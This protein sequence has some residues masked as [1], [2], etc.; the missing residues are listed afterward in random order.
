MH[1]GAT[2]AAGAG[3]SQHLR[4]RL[5]FQFSPCVRERTI[6]M[7]KNTTTTVTFRRP[8][9]L[10]GFEQM[11]PAGSYIVDIEEERVDS[12]VVN[13]WRRVSTT[14]RLPQPGGAI[15]YVPVNP[16]ALREALLRDGAQEQ[17]DDTAKRR[18]NRARGRPN[19]AA[20]AL[21]RPR[22]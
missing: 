4:C 1:A 11:Q 14:M 18:L 9:I 12:L 13:A 21:L 6:A 8:F 19:P 20:I 15:E 7:T 17:M 5:P 16:E 2:A 22:K 10:D 3:E